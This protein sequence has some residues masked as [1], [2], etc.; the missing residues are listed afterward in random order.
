MKPTETKSDY[1]LILAAASIVLNFVTLFVCVIVF[2]H[3]GKPNQ[4]LNAL[5][6]SITMIE[7][8][9]VIVALG[10]FWMLRTNVIATARAETQQYLNEQQSALMS[11]MEVV[12]RETAETTARR[13]ME[14]RDAA[15]PQPANDLQTE[16]FGQE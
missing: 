16:A 14:E 9:L 13:V 3:S 11:R 4:D 10:G 7:I 5:A 12:A 15:K 1:P 6:V 8:F 2:N